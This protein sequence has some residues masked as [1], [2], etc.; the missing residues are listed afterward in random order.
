VAEKL[1]NNITA[2]MVAA[3]RGDLTEASRLI[4]AGAGDIDATDIFG[5]TA[6]IYA[7]LAGHGDI[8]ELL[9]RSSADVKLKNKMGQDCQ[10]AARSRGH[11]QALTILRGAELLLLIRDGDIKRAYE[12]LDSGLDV[13]VQAIGSWTPLM[14]A[15]LENRSEM[16]EA[17][18]ERGAKT[19]I[20]NAQGLTAEM[21]AH[22]KGHE[23]IAEL[24]R[25]HEGQAPLRTQ[26]TQVVPDILDLENTPTAPPE[27]IVRDESEIIN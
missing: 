21:I 16:A 4:E 24:L 17:L 7:A 12:L 26:A 18:L 2:L 1:D 23:R 15:A 11:D 3:S 8:I 13:N 19:D 22:R 27:T 20:K 6:L 5:N 25:T 9:L 10:E 14:V